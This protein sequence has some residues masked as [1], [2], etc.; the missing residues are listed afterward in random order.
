MQAAPIAP[1]A[2]SHLSTA[3]KMFLN[4]SVQMGTDLSGITQAP[5]SQHRLPY[6]TF[7]L[8]NI[9]SGSH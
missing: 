8:H 9:V 3:L 6:E 1:I 2:I 5:A 4:F 7:L